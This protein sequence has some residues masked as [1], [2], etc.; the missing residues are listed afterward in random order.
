M[1]EDNIEMMSKCPGCGR[2][3]DLSAPSCPRGEAYARG[4]R[5]EES[6]HNHEHD[7]EQGWRERR[8]HGEEREDRSH[9]EHGEAFGHHGGH[10]HPE[11]HVFRGDK[12]PHKGH[13]RP[14]N[15]EEYQRL[16]TDG[17]LNAQMHLLHHMSRFGVE[18]R[19]GQGRILRILAE[20]GS[21]TQRTLTEKL[22]I[23]PGSASEVIG[24][25]E[26][27]GFIERR[28]SE[29]DRRTADVS[30][31]EAGMEQLSSQKQEKPNLF[32]ALSQEEKE[33]LLALLE[34]LSADWREKFPREKR[35]RDGHLKHE[36]RHGQR[37]DDKA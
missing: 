23:Q 5:P 28:E 4:E 24:K 7:R 1:S 12:G 27:A 20:E 34:K 15:E 19:G 2:H 11:E 33:Q 3:C 31:T 16:D 21:M 9:R 14:L 35:G 10:E 36:G 6:G 18:S 17:K 29:E 32:S 30:L 22:G 26:R 8:G 13:H 37:K 25:L